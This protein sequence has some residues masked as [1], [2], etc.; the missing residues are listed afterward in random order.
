MQKWSWSWAWS[1]V[2]GRDRKSLDILGKYGMYV[3]L[4]L[5]VDRCHH[6]NNSTWDGTI[7]SKFIQSIN[8]NGEIIVTKVHKHKI[9]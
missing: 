6:M 3:S 7:G 4:L 2:P 9:K 1:L 8:S 5:M